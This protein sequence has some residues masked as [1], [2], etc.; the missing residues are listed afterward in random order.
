MKSD[1]EIIKDLHDYIWY[2][3]HEHPHTMVHLHDVLTQLM[4]IEEGRAVI[5][6]I[7]DQYV[8]VDSS[9]IPR[10]LPS[11]GDVE[12]DTAVATRDGEDT[13]GQPCTGTDA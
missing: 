7:G 12:D 11:V 9:V 3:A 6:K 2:R 1:R 5:V 10:G 13:E 8:V 4:K